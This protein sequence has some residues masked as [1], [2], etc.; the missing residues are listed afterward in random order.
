VTR[1]KR[2]PHVRPPWTK[3]NTKLAS[4]RATLDPRHAVQLLAA[5]KE[6]QPS[7]TCYGIIK[8]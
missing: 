5:G 7:I 6:V 3:E 4:P 2:V 1:S 8:T